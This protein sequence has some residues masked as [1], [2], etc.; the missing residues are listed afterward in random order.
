LEHRDVIALRIQDEDKFGQ[1]IPG[2]EAAF[3]T[4][5]EG[6]A[7]NQAESAGLAGFVESGNERGSWGRRRKINVL[8]RGGLRGCCRDD[9]EEDGQNGKDAEGFRKEPERACGRKGSE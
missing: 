3:E 6:G 1:P 8:L 5:A 9:S 2:D 4:F 7:W